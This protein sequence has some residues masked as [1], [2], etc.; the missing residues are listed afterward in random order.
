MQLIETRAQIRLR[1]VGRGVSAQRQQSADRLGKVKLLLK[2][3]DH[4]GIRFSWQEPTRPRPSAHFRCSHNRKLS[5]V[6]ITDNHHSDAYS[7]TPQPSHTS[8]EPVFTMM[9]RRWSG[10]IVSQCPHELFLSGNT[11]CTRLRER[12]RS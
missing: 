4:N 11:A 5:A 3:F 1:V 7:I 9:L 2:P 12:I 10:S 8:V 6:Q